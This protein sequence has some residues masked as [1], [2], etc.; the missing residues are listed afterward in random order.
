MRNLS[1]FIRGRLSSTSSSPFLLVKVDLPGGSIGWT[2]LPYNILVSSQLYQA[3]AGILSFDLPIQEERLT[4]NPYNFAL[5]D[6]NR[7]HETAMVATG[8]GAPLQVWLGFLDPGTGVP[9]TTDL[10]QIYGG[11]IDT[12][13]PRESSNGRELVV[14]GTSPSGALDLVRPVNTTPN[15]VKM[16]N[17]NDISMDS[18]ITDRFSEEVTLWGKDKA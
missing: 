7:A 15:Y 2:T 14:S 16:F 13:S 5:S 17:I 3:D 8:L 18:L 11:T 4:R 12:I 1:T 9:N 6:L 10:L